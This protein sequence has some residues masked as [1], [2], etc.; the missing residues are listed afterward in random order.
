MQHT[1]TRF[2]LLAA[3]VLIAA[4][5]PATQAAQPLKVTELF[6]A[7]EAN[8]GKQ[9]TIE[10]MA[11]W[12]CPHMGCKAQLT[13]ADGQSKTILLVTQGKSMPR[14]APDLQGDT[15]RV[16]GILHE[17]RI[18]A[19]DLDEHEKEIKNP[20][21]AEAHSHTHGEGHDHAKG[22]DDCAD[23]PEKQKPA[24]PAQVAKARETQLAR[25]AKYRELLA[26]SKK[27]Y[28]ASYTFEGQSWEKAA[29]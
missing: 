2:K 27:G 19:A 18:T 12:V 7:V 22:G 24:D 1:H 9:V 28:L 25:I 11:T 26:K 15:L 17:N 29:Q 23:C 13:D 3:L 8:V 20:S 6:S 4:F 10:G 14:F 5:I 21:P 16:T